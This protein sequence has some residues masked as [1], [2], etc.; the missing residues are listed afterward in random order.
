MRLNDIY[1][2]EKNENLSAEYEKIQDDL[3]DKYGTGEFNSFRKDELFEDY[4]DVSSYARRTHTGKIKDG[5]ELT[6][7]EVSMIC[8]GGYSHFGGS[9]TIYSDKT[10]KVEIYTD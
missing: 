5:M 7:L 8:D 6:E 4:K 1:A 3:K 9:S 2:V 10:F